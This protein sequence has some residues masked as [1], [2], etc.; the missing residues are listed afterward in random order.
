MYIAQAK[1]RGISIVSVGI[2]PWAK[3]EEKTQNKHVGNGVG[4]GELCS[5]AMRNGCL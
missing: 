2:F 3:E 1:R 5:V 4:I